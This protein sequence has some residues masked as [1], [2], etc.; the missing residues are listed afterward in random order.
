[1][2]D[3]KRMENAMV[4]QLTVRAYSRCAV[5]FAVRYFADGVVGQG[6]VWDLSR[7]GWRASGSHPV[8]MGLEMAVYFHLPTE[9]EWLAV[10]QAVVR[11]VDGLTFGLEILDIDESRQARLENFLATITDPEDWTSHPPSFSPSINMW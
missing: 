4:K 3:F 9:N 11:W 7:N 1:M 10:D 8:S 6:T 2:N 5:R